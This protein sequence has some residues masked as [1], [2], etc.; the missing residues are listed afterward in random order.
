MSAST[1]FRCDWQGRTSSRA[2]PSCGAPLYRPEPV[3][4]E[5]VRRGAPDHGVADRGVADRGGPGWTGTEPLESV[6]TP[7]SS[8][9]SPWRVLLGLGVVMLAIVGITSPLLRGDTRGGSRGPVARSEAA[10]FAGQGHG[11]LVY[12][13]TIGPGRGRQVL[14][15]VDL[16]SGDSLQGPDIPPTVDIVDVSVAPGWVGLTTLA[17]RGEEVFLLR[18]TTMNVTPIPL[19]RGEMVAWGTGGQSVAFATNRRVHTGCGRRV[20]L[21]VFTIPSGVLENVLHERAR[22]G[23]ILSIGHTDASTFFTMAVGHRVGVFR[24]GVV[25]V[26]HEVLDGYAM[27]SSSPVG[28]LL[29]APRER[30]AAAM[31]WVG[32]GAPRRLGSRGEALVVDRV[33]AWSADGARAAVLGRMGHRAGVFLVRG[34]PSRRAPRYVVPSGDHLDATFNDAG[35]LYLVID[36]HVVSYRAGMLSDVLL[37]SDAPAPNG[38]IAWVP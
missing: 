6:S 11:S 12:T 28:D 7:R 1:C 24:T 32:A 31:F 4:H 27:L 14:W 8:P 2:C 37:P 9:A 29:V 16:D 3:R 33:L 19:G 20:R 22:C 13:T 25:G 38:P 34:G 5:R 35:T 10:T 26:P 23:G 36:G 18:G 17:P 15:T 30:P 21:D